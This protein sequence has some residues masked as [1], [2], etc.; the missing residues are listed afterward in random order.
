MNQWVRPIQTSS[1]SPASSMPWSRLGL[2]LTSM[3]KTPSRGLL[4][5]DAVEAVADAARRPHRRLDDAG[6]ASSSG[7]VLKPPSHRL[8]VRPVLDDLPVL[9]WPSGTGRR[10]A[11]CRRGRRR[12]SRTSV[13]MKSWAIR[14]SES[15][16]HSWRSALSSL[17]ARRLL[18]AAREGAVGD[19]QHHREAELCGGDLEVV[20][21]GDDHG[22]RHRHRSRP[23]A[24]AGR[25]CWCSGSSRS[26]RR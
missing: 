26:G 12:A 7:M 17:E 18:D 24:R 3:T 5:V 1:F 4:D 19:L 15:S 2:S 14:R 16:S 25:S 13:G 6:G 10:R 22:R 11:A 23:S 9:A 21:A 20:R 8:A